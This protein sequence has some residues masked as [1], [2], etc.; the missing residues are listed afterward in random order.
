MK[1]GVIYL[2]ADHAGFT[3][4]EKLKRYFDSLGIFYEDLG[5]N[6]EK[7]DDYPD[8]AFK[9]ASRVAREK[10]ARGILICGTGTGMVIAANKVKGIR[11]AVGYDNY[12]VKMG[13]SHNNINILCLRGR[14]FSDV[15]NLRLVKIWLMEKFSGGE[16]HKRRLRKIEKRD[17]WNFRMKPQ[18]S[19]KS[20]ISHNATYS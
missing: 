16:R 7:G 8:F 13:R 10:G 9:V 4:K 1:K 14:K 11:A 3:L 15:E 12:S 19:T 20:T 18:N 2:G 17:R 6:G 5:G